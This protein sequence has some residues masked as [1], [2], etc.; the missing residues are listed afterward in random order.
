M[1][2]AITCVALLLGALHLV[3]IPLW[4]AG[5]V[6]VALP[7]FTPITS[8]FLALTALCVANL[9]LG[10]W[11]VRGDAVSLWV[12]IAFAVY[13]IG[14]VFY[15][16]TWPSLLPN[17][18][19]MLGES[20]NTAAVLGSLG[21][22]A[23]GVGLFGAAIVPIS[24]PRPPL[25]RRFWQVLLG[26]LA[27][28]V[29]L[30]GVLVIYE[31]LLPVLVAG[32][33]RFTRA[34]VLWNAFQVVLFGAG[35]F[36]VARRYARSG[37]RL[38]GY[39]CFCQQAYAFMTFAF[40]IGG[41]RYDL[42]WYMDRLVLLGGFLVALFGML[43]EYVGLLKREH[44]QMRE[45][46]ARSAELAALL[47]AV[48]AV[49]WIAHDPQC[50]RITGNQAAYELLRASHEQN[51]S[52]SAPAGE[53]LRHFWVRHRGG[54]LATEDLPVQRAARGAEIRDFEEEIV[55][56]DGSVTTLF[57]NATPL[58]AE[59]GSARG[60]V[61]AFLDI[62][63]RKQL[64]E[65]LL[66]AQKMDSMGRL[67]GGVAHDFNN[68]LTAIS[69]YAALA[70]DT[71]PADSPV[72]N[73]LREI[74]K[75]SGRA[76]TLTRRLLAFA[77]RQPITLAVLDLNELVSDIGPLLHRLLGE[78]IR[79]EII[80]APTSQYVDADLGQLEQVVIN[81]AVN[82]RDAMPRGGTLRIATA[83]VELDARYASGHIDVRA[84]SYCLLSVSDTGEGMSPEVQAHLFEPFFTTKPVGQGTGLGLSTCYGIV[85]QHSGTIWIYSELGRGT[86]AKVYLPQATKPAQPAPPPQPADMPR[87]AETV[88]VVEDEDPVRRLVAQVLQTCGYTV[89]LAAH[90]AEALQVGRAHA[91]AAIHLLLTDVVMPGID[92]PTLAEQIRAQFPAIKVLFMSGYH[93]HPALPLADQAAGEGL[94]YK[95]FSPA[96]LAQ[97]V[98]ARLDAGS[99]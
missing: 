37:D 85:K 84:G 33:G 3:L 57:G 62:T 38:L 96:V 69:G 13:S 51:L 63:A 41:K 47:D 14:L 76:A 83:T 56:E 81:L 74:E 26:W 17:G 67:A 79:L 15:V 72:A 68:L 80:P 40:L 58:R 43:A 49:V 11:Q 36:C 89:L 54:E 77:R 25:A 39:V 70:L 6:L 55:F 18:R 27:L 71:L 10:R 93:N 7:W 52:Q 44:A 60:A 20:P 64:E 86:E 48:P 82:A 8:A 46:H 73:D 53:R 22:I 90:G 35:A 29:L 94:L 78:Q 28:A 98:R 61:A 66:R 12:G 16:L 59:D 9:A 97:R 31:P 42:W 91:P 92:G 32:D 2:Y 99:T 75:A 50:R 34:S 30:G 87:G 88:L 24:E 1:L 19:A 95:P 65:Q 4:G 21:S 5:P 23:L 45:L